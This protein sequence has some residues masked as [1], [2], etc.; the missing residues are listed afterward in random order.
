MRGRGLGGYVEMDIP[1]HRPSALGRLAVCDHV[2]RRT[3][4]HV[5]VSLVVTAY[6][7]IIECG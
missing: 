6:T 4:R 5:M 3:V 7:D 2:H 1:L